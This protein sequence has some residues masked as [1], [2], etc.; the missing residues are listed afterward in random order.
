[1]RTSGWILSV[2]SKASYPLLPNSPSPFRCTL[3]VPVATKPCVHRHQ[4]CQLCK[5]QSAD[6]S[7]LEHSTFWNINVATR[8]LGLALSDDDSETICR[9][10]RAGILSGN[11]RWTLKRGPHMLHDLMLPVSRF[12]MNLPRRPYSQP[13]SPRTGVF[14]R[15]SSLV[16][17]NEVQDDSPVS[18]SSVINDV[19]LSSAL[20]RT[21]AQW[22]CATV[23]VSGI[24]AVDAVAPVYAL[25]RPLSVL[26]AECALSTR[27]SGGG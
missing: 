7:E 19:L 21:A 16:F 15:T 10:V 11:V 17:A 8:A 2:C 20:Y 3:Y 5:L 13:G 25:S 14:S 22:K 12:S 26:T 1:M 23:E 6:E 18:T 27:Q 24:C 4:L 9:G